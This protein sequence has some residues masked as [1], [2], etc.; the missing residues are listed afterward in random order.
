MAGGVKCEVG[1]QGQQGDQSLGSSQAE[2]AADI[3]SKAK[4]RSAASIFRQSTEEF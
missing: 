4:V 2:V 1:Q 3:A